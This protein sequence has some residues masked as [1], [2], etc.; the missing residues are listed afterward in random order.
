MANIA[1]VLLLASAAPA[2]GGDGE[3]EDPSSQRRA[4]RWAGPGD[5]AALV[6]GGRGRREGKDKQGKVWSQQK[7]HH[8]DHHRAIIIVIIIISVSASSILKC[9]KVTIF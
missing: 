8:D 4:D 6:R 1:P 9:Y 5:A 3:E 7:Y 2:A